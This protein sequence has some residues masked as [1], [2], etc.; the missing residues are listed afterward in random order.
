MMTTNDDDDD[1]LAGGARETRHQKND[2]LTKNDDYRQSVCARTQPR[3]TIDVDPLIVCG[4]DGPPL[5]KHERVA[6]RRVL[7]WS[8]FRVRRRPRTTTMCVLIRAG[9]A[10]RLCRIRSGQQAGQGAPPCRLCRKQ[11]HGRGRR[12]EA[13]QDHIRVAPHARDRR[14]R[15]VDHAQPQAARDGIPRALTAAEAD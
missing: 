15:Q 1:T 6:E 7:E 10:D 13:A 11:S 9:P 2:A 5:L 4:I 8:L 3:M 12:G 14:C